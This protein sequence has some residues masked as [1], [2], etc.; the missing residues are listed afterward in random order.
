MVRVKEWKKNGK[1]GWEVDIRVTLPDGTRLRERVKS[2]VSSPSGSRRWAQQREALLLAQGGRKGEEGCQP[3]PTLGEFWPRFMEG[4]AR[5][6][7]E[8]PNQIATRERIWTKHLEPAFGAMQL[9]AIGDEEVQRFK[10][11]LRALSPK[12]VNNILTNV[13]R[14]LGVAVE[15][16]ALRSMPCRIRQLKT[17][18]PIVEFYEEA[19]F[20]RLLASAESIDARTHLAVL[21]GGEA[22]LR[23]GEMLGLCWADIDSPRAMLKVQRAVSDDGTLTLP[24]SGKP[25]IVLMTERLRA[26][27]AA[28]RHLRGERVF[29]ADDGKPLDKWALKW[30]MTAPSAARRTCA[31]AGGSTSCGTRSARGSPRGACPC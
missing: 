19:E 24:K 8:K 6:N 15:W 18:K 3:V 31:L 7:K 5:A 2:P 22:G 29:Y 14:C 25:R 23:L 26:A 1:A 11:S 9:D 16:G 17:S 28:H 4:Y 30:M 21:L 13:R 27:L 10:G 20:E 12:S